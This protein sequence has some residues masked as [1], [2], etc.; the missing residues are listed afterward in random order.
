M[1]GSGLVNFHMFLVCLCVTFNPSRF[2][3]K[4]SILK[5]SHSFKQPTL[6]NH[7]HNIGSHTH[8]TYSHQLPQP[9]NYCHSHPTA[10][11]LTQ[12]LP[13]LSDCFHT[14]LTTTT[15]TPSLPHPPD[16]H[17]H[18]NNAPSNKLLPHLSNCCHTRQTAV[19]PT[20]LLSHPTN[21]CH[22]YQTAS[23]P[24]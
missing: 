15:P 3:Y 10:N 13:H 11:T 21:C 22:T 4:F 2:A 12:L 14:H 16:C 9:P 20:Q 5:T 18:P 7:I 17:N 19:I 1:V 24:I 23:T 6:F 8:L